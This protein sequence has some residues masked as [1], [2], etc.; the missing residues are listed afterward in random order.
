MLQFINMVK[1]AA[2]V[3][4]FEKGQMILRAGDNSAQEMYILLKGSA[5]AY[6]HS[7]QPTE[8]Q[9]A[10][11]KAGDF[12]GEDILFLGQIP[13]ITVIATE[14][15]ITLPISRGKEQEFFTEQPEAAFALAQEFCWRAQHNRETAQTK[16]TATV[17]PPQPIASA[18]F[19]AEHIPA[20][21]P[22]AGEDSEYLFM[23]SYTCPICGHTF[24]SLSIKASKLEAEHTDTDL[25][26]H[27]ANIEPLYYDVVTCPNCWYSALT[28][29]FK[30][31]AA[32]K[33]QIDQLLKDYK[34]QIKL[35][36][37]GNLD[38]LT[39]F[40]GYYLALACAPKCFRNYHA[41]MGK[42]WLKLSHIYDDCQE[43]KMA[44][45]ATEQA[46]KGYMSA[47]ENSAMPS[48]QNQQLYYIIGELSLRLNDL[49]TAR[50]FFF[51]AKVDKEGSPVVTRHAEDRIEYLR[52]LNN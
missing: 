51:Q 26:V 46:L 7:G 43:E 37:D 45:H 10:A 49:N 2:K 52:T 42:L 23:K 34:S 29:M 38:S 6:I 11:Y 25:R 14:N 31:G 19:P 30:E 33:G 24:K 36:T 18:L 3:K 47:Y 8:Q 5:A 13:I 12:F 41:S 16:A 39:V 22:L 4:R 21:L 1:C 9:I 32:Q 20:E 50:K 35:K 48:K 27:Y 44:L 15:I 28:E 17:P 40:A